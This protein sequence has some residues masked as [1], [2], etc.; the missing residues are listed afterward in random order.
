[1]KKK[2]YLLVLWIVLSLIFIFA[3][4]YSNENE[5]GICEAIGGALAAIF[6]EKVWFACQDIAD[7]TDWKS[8]QRKL[9]RSGI[10]K[11]DTLV[12]ISFAYLYRIK[13]GNEYLLVKNARGTGKYQPVGGVYKIHGD[14]RF[15]LNSL[16]HVVDDNK[17]PID[18][19]SRDDY[20]LQM[21]C[22]YLRKFVKRF[23]SKKANRERINNVSRE[24]R[25]ELAGVLD[26]TSLSY[27]Y[28]GRH[29]TELKYGDHFCCYELL[30]ADVVELLP[31]D[32]QRIELERLKTQVSKVYQ[33]A[34]SEEI[35]A[36]GVIPGTQKLEEWIADHSMKMIQENEQY[37]KK[38]R[39]VG[40]VFTVATHE[41]Q[42]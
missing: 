1:M 35:K 27:R 29:M 26:W 28:C 42:S 37:L 20:R 24:F 14:E 18:E 6:I 17:V 36:L 40:Q 32:E 3:I 13:V 16:F 34:T 9:L 21:P 38:E 33:F 25:E 19:S 31:T 11:K 23:D 12:R 39:E 41:S 30:L 8:S 2:V 10:I 5:L 4:W 22:H 7:S 15:R